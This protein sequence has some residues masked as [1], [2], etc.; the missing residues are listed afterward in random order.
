MNIK[1]K[2]RLNK[3]NYHKLVLCIVLDVIGMLPIPF[4]SVVWAPASAYLLLKLFGG[5]MK[6]KLA[7]AIGFLE[8]VLPFTEMLPTF[9]I[10]WLY[11]TWVK[12]KKY[13]AYLP[14]ED[15]E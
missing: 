14:T 10:F 7:A 12:R 13:N 9:V 15:I 11:E 6:G 2:T 8:E 5:G 4:F 3:P 1:D